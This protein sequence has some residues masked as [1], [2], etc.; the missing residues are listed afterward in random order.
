MTYFRVDDK[1]W[2]HPKVFSL[3]LAAR[4]LWVTAGSYCSAYLTDGFIPAE[5]I[6]QLATGPKK[7][8]EKAV[9]E[10]VNARLWIKTDD[11]WCFNEWQEHNYSRE[12]VIKDRERRRKNQA[13]YRGRR[14]MRSLMESVGQRVQ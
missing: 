5:A 10:L 1:F 7:A 8:V 14:D 3:S 12:T 2:A 4:G 11:G 6:Q 9:E 13:A